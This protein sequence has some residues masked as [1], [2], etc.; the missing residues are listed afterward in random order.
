[1]ALYSEILLDAAKNCALVDDNARM[2]EDEDAVRYSVYLKNAIAKLNSNPALSFGVE[3]AFIR[4]WM[5]DGFGLFAR[6]VRD[7]DSS[8]LR[9]LVN[10]NNNAAQ[11]SYHGADPSTDAL[12]PVSKMQANPFG[13]ATPM[14]EIPQRLLKALSNP[15]GGAPGEY[16]IVGES[17]FFA[18]GRRDRVVT[19]SVRESEGLVRVSLAAPMLLIFDR[20]IPYHFGIDNDMANAGEKQPERKMDLLNIY[21]DLPVSHV[22]YLT[23]SA[24]L[25]LAMGLKLEASLVEQLKEQLNSQEKDLARNNVREKVFLS[26]GSRDYASNFWS[27][28]AYN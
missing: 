25:E 26:Y 19:Y 2:L 3:K 13:A 9:P 20:A 28:R 10:E 14:A 1:M 16:R 27:R 21:I 18:T 8:L 22:P 5:R 12:R 7:D 17:Q 24:A 23:M 15:N 6:L 11:N 4:N